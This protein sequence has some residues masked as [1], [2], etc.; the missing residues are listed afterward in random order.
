ME[1]GIVGLGLVGNAIAKRLKL[2]GYA[3]SG[4]DIVQEACGKASEHGVLI[5]PD[6]ASVFANARLVI[7]CLMTSDDRREV[8][9]GKQAAANALQPSTIILDVSTSRPEDIVIDNQRLAEQKSR[10]VDVCLSGSSE[11]IANGEALAL[12]GDR[13]NNAPYH[14]LLKCFTKEQY[15]FGEA[16]DGNRMKL[17][18]NLVYGLN[19]LVLAEALGLASKSKFDLQLTLDVLKAGGT[20]SRCMDTKGPKMINGTYEPP[21]ARL[22]QHYKDTKLILEY[23][24]S[25]GAQTPVS[26]L[27]SSL[28]QKL[29]EAGYAELDNAA[30]YKAFQ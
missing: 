2:A 6:A 27:H 11:E 4:F 15:Y 25:V 24:Q 28:L 17:I 30:V 23:A 1:I 8:L 9:W 16:G 14:A 18:V 5:Q 10:L 29:V 12:I 3:V 13:N 21:V 20:Y 7:L 22:G 26:T 19:R